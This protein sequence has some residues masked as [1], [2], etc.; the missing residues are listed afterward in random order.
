MATRVGRRSVAI[1][2]LLAGTLLA[3]LPPAVAEAKP[4]PA[5]RCF[6]VEATG[7][8]QDLGE[9]RTEATIYVHGRPVGT[10]QAM[11]TITGATETAVSFAG[12]IEF[13]PRSLPGTLVA[14]VT[15]T[16]D[17]TSGQ[18]SAT[19]DAVAGAG[20]LSGVT[21][22]VAISGTQLATG[23]FTETLHANLCVSPGHPHATS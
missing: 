3:W 18:F 5:N 16:V 21:G 12:P 11:F 13:T 10:T 15:G 8:G 1:L 19:S 4:P 22:S 17:L 6:S 2:V 20:R 9:G 23:E 7:V 14:P